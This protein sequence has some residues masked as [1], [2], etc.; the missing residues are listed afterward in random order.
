MRQLVILC[1]FGLCSATAFSQQQVSNTKK[2]IAVP[3]S[4]REK[5]TEA[6]VTDSLA[7]GTA[8]KTVE[9]VVPGEEHKKP[10]VPEGTPVLNSTKKRPE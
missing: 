1:G 5:M 7:I 9:P 8:K 3:V 4:S 10:A 6:L 2:P